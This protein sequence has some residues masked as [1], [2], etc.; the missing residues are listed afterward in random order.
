MMIRGFMENIGIGLALFVLSMAGIVSGQEATFSQAIED[1]SFFI[2]EAY[3]QESRVVQH[4]SNGLYFSTPEKYFGYSFTDEWPVFSQLHQLSIT[5]PYVF[6]GGS[7]SVGDIL[8]NYRYMLMRH[9]AW[10]AVAPR[11]SIVIPTGSREKGAGSG[12]TGLQVNIPVSK[13]LSEAWAG[14]FNAG[15]TLLPHVKS[16]SDETIKKSLISCNL[17]GSIIWLAR[18]CLNFLMEYVSTFSSEINE[19]GALAHSTEQIV[20]PGLRYAVN[21]GSLQIVP[22]IAVPFSFREGGSRTGVFLYL[23]FEHPF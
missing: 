23:S 3:N 22:G 13:R 15:F 4:I 5:I 16:T 9:D 20:S 2:E 18:P 8:I 11:I 10:A 21:L 6:Q 12:V 14:H 1:N 19:K 7:S 17:G